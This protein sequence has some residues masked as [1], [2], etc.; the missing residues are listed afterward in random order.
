MNGIAL[1]T[2][3]SG[4]SACASEPGITVKRSN[5]YP[6]VTVTRGEMASGRDGRIDAKGGRL[7]LQS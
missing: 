2:H 6:G 1:P 7:R 5:G 4:Q 3:S